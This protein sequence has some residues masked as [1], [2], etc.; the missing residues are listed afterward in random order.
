MN[1][2]DSLNSGKARLAYLDGDYEIIEPG[3]YVECAVTGRKIPLEA[4]RY[5]SV[6]RQEA[7]ADAATA[8]NAIIK[9]MEESGEW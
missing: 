6:D 2:L 9:A 7:Y 8:N 4:L 3:A 1:I 5:W